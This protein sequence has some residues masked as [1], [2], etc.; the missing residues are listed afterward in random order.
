MPHL[1]KNRLPYN[2]LP[3]R[4]YRIVARFG[5]LGTVMDIHWS[6]LLLQ[7]LQGITALLNTDVVRLMTQL[8]LPKWLDRPGPYEVLE[9]HV[10]L[11]LRDAAGK[12]AVYYKDQ[13][14]RFIQNNVI[15]YQDKAW[16]EGNI[17]ADYKCAPGMVVD[18]YREGHR[19]RVLVS[20]RETKNRGDL[21]TFHIERTITDGF[22]QGQEDFQID[23][24]HRTYFLSAS[25]VFPAS[26]PPKTITII[27]QN[28]TRSIPLDH[29]HRQVLA[30]GRIQFTWETKH[31]RLYESYI[32]AWQW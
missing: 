25:V 14:V 20:L 26:R 28:M 6:Q 19:W 10:R 8:P 11:E 17:F 13:Q 27:E 4:S 22:T 5:M 15:A 31:P 9:H 12:Q 29:R 24:D 21:E 16:G 1:C 7:L 32:L 23:V 18:R 2:P 30:D 3:S